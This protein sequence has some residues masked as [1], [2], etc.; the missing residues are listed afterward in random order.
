MFVQ[1]VRQGYPN[2]PL[3][4][5]Q[6]SKVFC[7]YVHVCL[8]VDHFIRFSRNVLALEPEGSILVAQDIDI[9]TICWLLDNVLLNETIPEKF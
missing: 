3:F 4:L 6:I 9:C 8:N 5:P 1:M 7:K 2:K